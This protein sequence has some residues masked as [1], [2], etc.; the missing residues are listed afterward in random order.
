MSEIIKYLQEKQTAIG[1]MSKNLTARQFIQAAS[2]A[3]HQDQ[4]VAKCTKES[5]FE[6]VLQAARMGLDCSGLH[7]HG[8][9]IAYG[10]KCTFIPGWQGLVSIAIRSSKGAIRSIKPTEVCENDEFEHIEGLSPDIPH[11]IPR[12][13][14]GAVEAAYA[15]AEFADG[16]QLF[17][18]VY[19]DDIEKIAS[20]SKSGAWKTNFAAMAR[21][22]AVRRLCSYLPRTLELDDALDLETAAEQS[23]SPASD[24]RMM[25]PETLAADPVDTMET[26]KSTIKKRKRGKKKETPRETTEAKPPETL[27]EADIIE[28][29]SKMLNMIPDVDGEHFDVDNIPF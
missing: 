25:S 22:T 26:V 1:A 28:A 17:T 9:L 12:K 16:N 29:N 7:G 6:A 13:N 27:T 19:L 24:L 2:I 20:Q 15:V 18:V 4:A 5:V 3:I 11:K 23:R 14:R 10:R 21:K 8:H